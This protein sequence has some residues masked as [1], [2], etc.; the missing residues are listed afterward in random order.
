MGMASSLWLCR[1]DEPLAAWP[2]AV[3]VIAPVRYALP[4]MVMVAVGTVTVPGLSMVQV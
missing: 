2:V 4:P 1:E 3:M